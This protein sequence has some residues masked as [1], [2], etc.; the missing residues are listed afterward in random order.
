MAHYCMGDLY[1]RHDLFEMIL[2]HLKLKPKKDSVYLLG[3]VLGTYSGGFQ[4]LK[5]L[6]EQ[7]KVFHLIRGTYEE[8]FLSQYETLYHPILSN[9]ALKEGLRPILDSSTK[10]FLEIHKIL[11]PALADFLDQTEESSLEVFLTGYPTIESWAK[12]H[13]TRRATLN[14]C[15][16]FFQTYNY[17]LEELPLIQTFLTSAFDSFE[18]K[19]LKQELLSLSLEEVEQMVF[20][21]HQTPTQMTLKVNKETFA[22]ANTL[23]VLEV[24][25]P[26]KNKKPTHFVFG[27]T[28][29]AT[30][31]TSVR[32]IFDFNY[33]EI[34]S[35]TDG[36]KQF[37]NLNLAKHSVA[38]LRLE[39]LEEFYAMNLLHPN[40]NTKRTPETSV[41]Q[42]KVKTEVLPSSDEGIQRFASY[43]HYGLEYFVEVNLTEEKVSVIEFQQICRYPRT[44]AIRYELPLSIKKKT[45]DAILTYIRKKLPLS[46]VCESIPQQKSHQKR[47]LFNRLRKSNPLEETNQN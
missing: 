6:M 19:A 38:A 30:I 33:R 27:N 28:P 39:D 25:E 7:P 11:F 10:A 3:N 21:L 1:G 31:H 46:K 15:L 24:S 14:A 13:K 18:D 40:E 45:E 17:T 41:K 4:I 9:D 2:N 34:L 26:I 12:R 5:Q 43:Q 36:Q 47:G 20:Y 23:E 22:L 35:F 42:R 8:R 16:S 37:Y 32:S 44:K 29:V